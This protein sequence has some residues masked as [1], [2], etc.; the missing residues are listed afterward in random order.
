MYQW[1]RGESGDTSNPIPGANIATYTT[2]AQTEA[3][4]YWVRVSGAGGMSDSR[5]AWV[6]LVP[7]V[8]V[9]LLGLWPGHPRG[10]ATGVQVAG[11]LA[12]IAAGNAGLAIYDLAE[13][14]A[15][16]RLGG[17]KA[18]ANGLALSGN[19]VFLACGAEGLQILDVSDPGAPVRLSH[20]ESSGDVSVVAVSGFYAYVTGTGWTRLVV[21][22]VSNPASPRQVGVCDFTPQLSV[23]A[24]TV[25]GPYAYLVGGLC[26]PDRGVLA[27]I[28]V[29]SPTGPKEVGRYKTAQDVLGLA[30]IG[31][32]AY[33]A[34]GWRVTNEGE[35]GRLEI[36]DI[37][38]PA[39]PQPVGSCDMNRYAKAVAV[40]AGYAYVATP[41]GG[42]RIIDVSNALKPQQ[43]GQYTP[44]PGMLWCA[45]LY[46]AASVTL[47]GSRAYVASANGLQVIDIR[48]PTSPKLAGVV[49]TD[50]F[51]E[52]VSV[53]GHY[54]YVADGCGGLQII[55]VADPTRP[56]SEA[57]YR[58]YSSRRV[59]LL[60]DRLYVLGPF[61]ILDVTSPSR[62]TLVGQADLYLGADA[63]LGAAADYAYVGGE[64]LLVVDVRNPVEPVAGGYYYHVG[65]CY[66]RS[67]SLQDGYAFWA[68]G[69]AGLQILDLSVPMEPRHVGAYYPEARA[70]DVAVRG[71]FAFLTEGPELPGLEVIDIGD[72]QCPTRAARVSLPR[73]NNIAMMGSYACVTGEGLEVFDVGD[74]Y[75]PVRVGHHDLGAEANRLQ[76]V[77]N[78]AHVAAGENG[79]AIYRL[80]PQLMLNPPMLDGDGLRLSWLGAPGI[81][82]Q[83]ATSLSDRDWQDVPDSEGLSSLRLS[84]TN[85]SVFFRLLRP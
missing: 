17:F 23:S 18:S 62:P 75:H 72:A 11:N 4:A 10:P 45:G 22:D 58:E 6:N 52:D 56:R 37:S 79:L 35:R 16:R 12:Y 64:N 44:D 20:F 78:L 85:A 8:S 2:P 59:A 70:A 48:S 21:L 53:S 32:H 71:E 13:P 50:A 41:G 80:A 30:T 19:V 29:S 76:V 46:D 67:M 68:R 14:A 43:V 33:L 42:L 15:P 39:N 55:D 49:W 3:S 82:L 54:A 57:V 60:G 34:E 81:R 9:E 5:T 83:R 28:D 38:N 73:A 26:D 66:G 7:P 74:P 36:L 77:G 24:M 31:N 25:I 1:Y 27:V 84:R 65:E 51:A 63:F 40:R 47:S 61:R 69:W